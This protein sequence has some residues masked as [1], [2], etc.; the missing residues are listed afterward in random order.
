MFLHILQSAN[1]AEMWGQVKSYRGKN[2]GVRSCRS[3]EWER[4]LSAYMISCRV[5]KGEAPSEPGTTR[6]RDLVTQET[7]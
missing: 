1:E 6:Q 3:S 2:S 7:R 4:A 5:L